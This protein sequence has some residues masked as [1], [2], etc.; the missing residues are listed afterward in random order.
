LH[1]DF[2]HKVIDHAEASA[3]GNV[4]TNGL[5]NVWSLVKRAINGT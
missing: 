2:V 5:E 3:K 4:H 1:W